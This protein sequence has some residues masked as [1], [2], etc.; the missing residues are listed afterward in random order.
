MIRWLFDDDVD[1]CE[2]NAEDDDCDI[3]GLVV[4]TNGDDDERRCSFSS[5]LDSSE[6]DLESRAP[7]AAALLVAPESST[8]TSPTP[9]KTSALIP[10]CFCDDVAEE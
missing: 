7:M 2:G 4:R 8:A 6:E 1:C 10:G 9:P 3:A 5:E